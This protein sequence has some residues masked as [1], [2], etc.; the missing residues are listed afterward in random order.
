MIYVLNILCLITF[1]LLIDDLPFKH[2]MKKYDTETRVVFAVSTLFTFKLCRLL[3]SQLRNRPWFNAACEDRFKALIRPLF[4]LS[5]LSLLQACP[6]FLV[7]IYTIWLLRWGYE[8]KT[9]SI[10]SIILCFAILGLE[11][12]E[13]VLHK[14]K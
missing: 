2:W 10:E 14:R 3:F 1:L 4:I 8:I 7:N 12:Y 6:I 9:L 11:I 13:F 5:M